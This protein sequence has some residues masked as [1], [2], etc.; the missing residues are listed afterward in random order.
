MTGNIKEKHYVVDNSNYSRRSM[1]C[2][3]DIIIYFGRFHSRPS[4]DCI[5]SRRHPTDTGKKDSV[6]M[7]ERLLALL[8]FI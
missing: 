5:D 4:G 7:Q 6:T 3:Y 1:A 8:Q 2:R